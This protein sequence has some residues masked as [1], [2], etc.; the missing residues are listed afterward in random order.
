M[1]RLTFAA[2]PALLLA[3]PVLAQDDAA[4]AV[5]AAVGGIIGILIVVVIGA[6]VGWLASLIVKGS[7]SGPLVDVLLG[8]GGSFLAGYLLPMLGIGVSS[9]VGNFI[10]ALVGAIV[11][12]LIFRLIRRA[13]G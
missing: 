2:L 3:A 4:Q 8:I 13:A 6:V 9:M 5:G 12:I 7:G 11:L 10:A 1:F